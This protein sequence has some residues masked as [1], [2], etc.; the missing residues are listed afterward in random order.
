MSA[1]LFGLVAA[2]CWGLHDFS[3]RYLSRTVPMLAAL[4]VALTVGALL[5]AGILMGRDAPIQLSEEAIYAC[6]VAGVAFL[7]ANL[8]LYFSLKRGPV[9]LVAPLVA[10]FPVLTLLFAFFG[11]ARLEPGQI[12]GIA[13]VVVGVGLVVS[14]TKGDTEETPAKLPTILLALLSSCG[15]AL[16]FHFGQVA[17]VLSDELLSSLM[18]RFTTLALLTGV[19]AVIKAEWRFDPKALWLLCAMGFLDSIALLSIISAAE[20]P[21]PAF[22]SV[23]AATFGIFTIFLAWLFLGERLNK[24]QIAGC[25]LAFSGIGYLS[26]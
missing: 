15:F 25:L 8:G 12:L 24:L 6:A 4:F 19:M 5:Q 23:S 1:I 3:I 16:T 26:L 13:V 14:L 2:L 22:A 7:T 20:L 18:T 10:T 17:A 11:G 21:N 9:G